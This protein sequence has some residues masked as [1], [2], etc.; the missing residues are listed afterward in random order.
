MVGDEMAK[1][2]VDFTFNMDHLVVQNGFNS[3]GVGDH[4]FGSTEIR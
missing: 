4:K 1:K 3:N 2:G